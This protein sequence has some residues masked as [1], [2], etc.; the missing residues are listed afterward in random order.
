MR[1]NAADALWLLSLM[2]PMPPIHLG[3]HKLCGKGWEMEKH[4]EWGLSLKR[5]WALLRETRR[6]R[7]TR[8]ERRDFDSVSQLPESN[9]SSGLLFLAQN[10]T[11]NRFVKWAQYFEI[12]DEHFTVFLEKR[13]ARGVVSPLR[14]LEVGVWRGGSL[15]LWRKYFGKAAIIFGVEI[16]PNYPRVGQEVAE[17]RFGSQSDP[18]FL[19]AVINEMGG[20][21]IVIDDGSHRSADV[22]A[23]IKHLFPRLASPGLYIIEDLHT[24]YWHDWGGGYGREGTSI[25]V[26][27]E[28]IDLLHSAYNKK[29]PS[30]HRLGLSRDQVRGLHFYDSMLVIEKDSVGFPQTFH[31]GSD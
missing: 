29:I 6:M 7:V 26:A 16:N 14:V 24:S 27:K 23:S 3:W 10:H 9:D 13:R 18:D 2:V 22:L 5:L 21:D 20:V 15:E 1:K 17:I 30:P 12:Y 19:A 25:E 11:G 28:L 8:Y 4:R 31:A